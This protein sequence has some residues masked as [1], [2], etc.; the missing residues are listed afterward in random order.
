[1][2]H[3]K[4]VSIVVPALFALICA[5]ADAQENQGTLRRIISSKVIKLGYLKDG[6]P[7]SFVIG[8]EKK[9]VGYA[10]DLCQRIAADI[11]QQLDVPSL[12]V[13]WVEVTQ[14]NRFDKVIDGSIDL[15]CGTSTNTVSRQKRVDFSLMTWIDGGNFLMKSDQTMKSLSDLAGKKIAVLGDTTTET[16]LREALK[17]GSINAQV[18]TVKEHLAGLNAMHRG[19]VDAYA[20]DQTVLI[21]LNIA[22]GE[23]MPMKLSEQNYSYEPYGLVL[24]RNDAEFK[25]VVNQTLAR[26]YRSGEIVEVYDRWFGKLGKPSPLLVTMYALNGLPE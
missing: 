10:V 12:A 4:L 11:Q 23:Q 2:S 22:V 13:Q 20:G 25:Q 26:L 8:P 7:F 1:V 15:E 17:R 6:V 18:V 14:T 16:T 5:S 21:G 19:E 9:P 3:A 24:R